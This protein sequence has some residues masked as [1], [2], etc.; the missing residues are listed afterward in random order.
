MITAQG[1]PAETHH[2]TTEDGYIL[3]MHRIPHGHP[4]NIIRPQPPTQKSRIPVLIFH[5]NA[6]SSADWVVN[7]PVHDALGFF[8]AD[9]GYDVW[10]ANQRGNTYST[11]HVTLTTADSKFWEFSVHEIGYYDIAAMVDYILLTTGQPR[12]HYIGFS[13]SGGSFMV[14]LSKRPEYNDKI[15]IGVLMAPGGI[16]YEGFLFGIAKIAGPVGPVY[17]LF[18]DVLGGIPIIP[19]FVANLMH[20]VL[21]IVCH[22]KVDLLGVCVNVLR[23]IFG[24]DFGLIG[25]VSLEV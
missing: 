4:N 7:T 1:Y 9:A 15:G 24:H 3:E 17:E 22:R 13:L 12:V 23:V 2:V 18:D 11:R 8:L 14:F 5:G 6:Q 10:L 19:H 16:Y 20:R 25:K 21:P